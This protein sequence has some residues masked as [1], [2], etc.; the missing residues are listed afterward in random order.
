MYI[1]PYTPALKSVWDRFVDSSR[2][3]VFIFRRDFMDYHADRFP[4]A[5]V[6]LYDDRDRL[7]ALFPATVPAPGSQVVTSHAGLTFGGWLMGESKPDALQMLEA[8]P[9]LRGYFRARGCTTLLYKAIPS[10]YH[11]YPCDENLYALFVN[12]ATID[13]VLMSSVIDLRRPLPFNTGA[14]RH[15]R[16]AGSLGLDVSESS[17]LDLFWDVL[18]QR[19]RERYAASPVHSLAEITMLRDR[20]P[21]NIRLWTV[22]TADG[23]LVAGTLLFVSGRVVKAQ[24][25]AS[26]QLGRELNAVDFLFSRLVGYYSG[27]GYDF[28]DLGPSNEDHGRVLNVGLV[29]QKCGYGARGIAYTTYTLSL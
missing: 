1:K 2:N 4:D 6:M 5:S 20:F 3:A 17:R 24:Y 23:D 29:S 10:I 25:I 28:F 18:T 21:D 22:C 13:T 15:V 16:R 14:K 8:W 26:S 7:L 27:L 12:N 9:L 11:S 19:L